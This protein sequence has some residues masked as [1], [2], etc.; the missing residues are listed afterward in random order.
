MSVLRTCCTRI[1]AREER[2]KPTI[3]IINILAEKK[4]WDL[5]EEI[6]KKNLKLGVLIWLK[7]RHP[8]LTGS[9]FSMKETKTNEQIVEMG[10]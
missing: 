1:K 2:N 3:Y 9:T 8:N 7:M 10:L 5:I 4:N 6:R